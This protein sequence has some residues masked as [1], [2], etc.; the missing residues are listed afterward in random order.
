MK[1]ICNL[2]FIIT[3]LFGFCFVA[4]AATKDTI[5][6]SAN[7]TE[8]KEGENVVITFSV[9]T[10]KSFVAGA[11]KYTF[12]NTKLEVVSVEGLSGFTTTPL[13]DPTTNELLPKITFQQGTAK[14]GNV[15]LVKLT[16]KA[17]AAFEVGTTTDIVITNAEIG[18]A[19]D[20]YD[21]TGASKTIT[22]IAGQATPDPDPEPDPKPTDEDDKK[23]TSLGYGIYTEDGEK[24]DSK[25]DKVTPKAGSTEVTDTTVSIYPKADTKSDAMCI[26]YRSTKANS[27]FEKIGVKV[28]CSGAYKV[29]DEDLK[30]ETTYYYRIRIYGGKNISDAIKITTKAKGYIPDT[31]KKSSDGS[32]NNNNNNKK[33]TINPID[34]GVATPIAAISL[35]G[36]GFIFIKKATKKNSLIKL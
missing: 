36:A 33:G 28:K 26:V 2:V 17:L 23:K 35:L 3:V 16:F 32:N 8:V 22:R 1:K 18:N 7:K 21:I 34:T 27:G 31:D 20:A 4:K 30:P 29:I 25:Y 24:I 19:T 5:I 14:T 12:D 13:N 15:T 11:F 6:M 10:D 9:N